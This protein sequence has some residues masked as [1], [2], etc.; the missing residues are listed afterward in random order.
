MLKNFQG[1]RYE[2]KNTQNS[3]FF[4]PNDYDLSLKI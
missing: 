2:N 1:S 3:N 4:F